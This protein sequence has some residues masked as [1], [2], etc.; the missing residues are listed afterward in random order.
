MRSRPLSGE[1]SRNRNAAASHAAG[2]GDSVLLPGISGNVLTG[3]FPWRISCLG[4]SAVLGTSQDCSR[5]RLL[6]TRLG[7]KAGRWEG[8]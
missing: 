5:A 8:M 3:A 7:N 2:A 4:V 1:Q 6:Y